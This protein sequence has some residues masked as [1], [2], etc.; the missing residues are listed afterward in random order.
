MRTDEIGQENHFPFLFSFFGNKIR[1]GEGR[2][3]NEIGFGE[4]M[5]KNKIE[6]CGHTG[7]GK[8]AES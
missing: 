4:A 1:F 3:K 7:M 8:C 6:I 5:T 2:I